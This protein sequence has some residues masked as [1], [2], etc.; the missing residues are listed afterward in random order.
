MA[1]AAQIEG[2]LA[3]DIARAQGPLGLERPGDR[4]VEIHAAARHRRA[5]RAVIGGQ[6]VA[7]TADQ[8]TRHRRRHA[9]HQIEPV[10]RQPRRQQ[11]HRQHD[12]RAPAQRAGQP[13]HHLLIGQPLRPAGLE[14]AAPSAGKGGQRDQ[15]GQ[16]IVERDRRGGHPHPARRHHHRQMRHQIAHHLE[17][18]RSRADDDAGA[19][20]DDLDRTLAQ[21]GPGLGARGQML[22]IARAWREPA[23]TDDPTHPRRARRRGEIARGPAVALGKAPPAGHG[24]DQVEG[25]V[26][27]RQRRR[28]ARRGE[29]V[30]LDLLDALPGFARQRVAAPRGHAHPHTG[31]LQPRHEV[32]PDM[33]ARA[34][35]ETGARRSGHGARWAG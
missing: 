2:A 12:R 3:P 18:G 10:A 19:Q 14:H 35:D 16:T 4:G 28:Q 7:Q 26:D 8:R 15:V 20:L 9:G 23:E 1:M 13:A 34:E 33:A 27:A 11:R 6:V 21:D 29:R 22:G 30:G 25:R 31:R 5:Q 32:A 24:M 17:G